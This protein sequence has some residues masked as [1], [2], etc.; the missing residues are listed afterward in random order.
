MTKIAAEYSDKVILT[1]DNPRNED[2][3]TIIAG[4]EAG[5]PK[6]MEHKII[7]IVNRKEAIKVASAMMTDGGIILVAGKGHELY[8]EVKGVRHPFDDRQVLRKCFEKE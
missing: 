3:E 1:S 4:M 7:S 6:G 5:I 2:P 8:Q